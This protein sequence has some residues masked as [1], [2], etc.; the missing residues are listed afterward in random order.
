MELEIQS[1]IMV[2]GIEVAFTSHQ[3]MW[4]LRWN[5]IS[6]GREVWNAWLTAN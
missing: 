1:G 3:A 6:V 5:L 4:L 2:E